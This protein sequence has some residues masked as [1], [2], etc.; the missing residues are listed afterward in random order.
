MIFFPHI[1][2]AGGETLKQLF[3][4]AFGKEKCL[5]IWDPAFGADYSVTQLV[6]EKD[7]SFDSY[8]AII[9]HLTFEEFLSVGSLNKMYLNGDIKVLSSVRDPIDRLI[10]LYN[11]VCV[12]SKHPNHLHMRSLNPLEFIKSQKANFQFEYLTVETGEGRVFAENM[13]LY[14]LSS[15][16]DMFKQDLEQLTGKSLKSPNLMNKTANFDSEFEL[17]DKNQIPDVELQKLKEKH[18]RDYE[19]LENALS[20]VRAS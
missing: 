20:N 7:I 11:Y 6:N 12:N 5:K 17:F 14:P 19:M 18:S 3:Y 10:S 15:S 1:P 2:K 16:I 9:G 4:W 8:S 13:L